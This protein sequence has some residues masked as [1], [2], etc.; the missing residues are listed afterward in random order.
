MRVWACPALPKLEMEKARQN[1]TLA[2]ISQGE[3]YPP[4]HAPVAGRCTRLVKGY[5]EHYGNVRLNSAIRYSTPTAMLAGY[6][7]EIQADRDRKL[8]AAREQWKNCRQ[9][10]A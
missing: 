7:Q 5:V 9:R 1:R 8:E 6:Q 4:G 10:I 3:V 2:Q